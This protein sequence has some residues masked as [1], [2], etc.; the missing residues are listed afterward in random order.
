MAWQERLRSGRLCDTGLFRVLVPIPEALFGQTTLNFPGPPAS[1]TSTLHA[2]LGGISAINHWL[3]MKLKPKAD[4]NHPARES[5]P[6]A[7]PYR[8]RYANADFGDGAPRC[9]W[10]SSSGPWLR[11]VRVRA[12]CRSARRADVN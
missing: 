7:G 3:A 4:L 11:R 6:N 2:A 5:L 9:R 1:R 12:D 8:F 10:T